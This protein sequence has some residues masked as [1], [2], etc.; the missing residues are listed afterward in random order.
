MR[1]ELLNPEIPMKPLYW[2][3]ILVQ[4]EKVSPD[5]PESPEVHLLSLSKLLIFYLRKNTAHNRNKKLVQF[6]L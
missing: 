3:R 6:H 5:S 2:T 1:K 4:G